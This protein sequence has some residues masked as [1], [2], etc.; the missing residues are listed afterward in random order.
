MR[1]LGGRWV[2]KEAMA[3]QAKVARVAWVVEGSVAG[4]D[5]ARNAIRAGVEVGLAEHE[6]EFEGQ[7]E[8]KVER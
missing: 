7:C 3:H 6:A 1:L 5:L 8:A 2:A 4:L